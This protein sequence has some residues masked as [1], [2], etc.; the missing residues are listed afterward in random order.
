MLLLFASQ[1]PCFVTL[2]PAITVSPSCPNLAV[3]SVRVGLSV[4]HSS[5]SAIYLTRG[6]CYYLYPWETDAQDMGRNE[7]KC[8][9]LRSSKTTKLRNTTQCEQCGK[10]VSAMRLSPGSLASLLWLYQVS[11]PCPRGISH[12]SSLVNPIWEKISN[13]N[14]LPFNF[15]K[16]S[17]I[18][19]SVNNFLEA[20]R[21]TVPWL[22]WTW[23]TISL[24]SW[25]S[26]VLTSVSV[27]Y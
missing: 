21:E 4:T 19:R 17:L 14:V 25:F 13:L 1:A 7:T 12:P 22:I 2:L 8:V 11:Q 24:K 3:L 5:V 18:R 6:W 9:Y 20:T 10:E 23:V 27:W 16:S 15:L 26:W